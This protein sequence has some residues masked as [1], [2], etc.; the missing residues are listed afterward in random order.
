MWFNTLA[1][2]A[3]GVDRSFKDNPPEAFFDRTKDGDLKGVANEGAVNP[4]IYVLPP[5]DTEVRKIA[6]MK[7]VD[8]ALEKGVTMYGD[9]YVFE[10]DLKPYEELHKEGRIRHHN[11]R[12]RWKSRIN[13]AMNASQA[14]AKPCLNS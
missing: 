1:M 3:A 12:L 5:I 14:T 11:S 7:L 2:E 4:F 10:H 6:I 13:V 8:E 9:A